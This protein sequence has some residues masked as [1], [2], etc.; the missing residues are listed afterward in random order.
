LQQD[1]SEEGKEEDGTAKKGEK[2]ELLIQ[3]EIP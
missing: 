3:D 1:T 2:M